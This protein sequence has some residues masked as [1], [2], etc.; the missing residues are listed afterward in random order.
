M[1]AI[2]FM[3][4]KN[5]LY[6]SGGPQN[7]FNLSLNSGGVFEASLT[8]PSPVQANIRGT[9]L[10][11]TINARTGDLVVDLTRL[12]ALLPKQDAVEIKGGIVTASIS[13]RGPLNEPS[14][15]GRATAQGLI[16]G[17]P[18]F[19]ASDAKF[20]NFDFNF[21][22]NEARFGP[23]NASIGKKGEASV[24]GTFRFEKWIPNNFDLHIVSTYN[25]PIPFDLAISRITASGN[26]SGELSLS[27]NEN[28]FHVGGDLTA[29][30]TEIAMSDTTTQDN[31][32]KKTSS[33]ITTTNFNLRTGRKVECIFP[34]ADFPIIRANADANTNIRIESDTSIEHYAIVGDVN[35]RSGEIFYFERSF[36]IRQGSLSFN[37][38]ETRFN[39]GLSARAETRDRFNN[40]NVTIAI[41]INNQSLLSF[42]PTFESTPPL[43]QPEILSLMGESFSGSADANNNNERAFFN[44]IGD[45]A[46][47][48]VVVRRAEKLIRDFFHLDMFSMRT[49]FIQNYIFQNIPIFGNSNSTNSNIDDDSTQ[50]NTNSRIASIFDNSTVM[51]GLFIGTDMFIQ[52]MA[53]FRYDPNTVSLGGLRIE[54]EIGFELKSPLFDISW[55]IV[56]T[57]PEY[58]FIPDNK[59]TLSRR[60]TL[61]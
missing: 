56:P 59:I 40:E 19:V 22:A 51:A 47:Q 46:A 41:V 52:L 15:F 3:R 5:E 32:P 48:F 50:D 9:I 39:P 44:S 30:D 33:I 57:H 25:K 43:S 31:A 8:Y 1:F 23:V 24:D 53:S 16:L 54:P 55:N 11:N 29:E 35:L 12:L 60:W 21:V 61:W 20:E 36:Y 17:V 4:Q 10:N 18:K 37:E 7:I 6:I 38:N 28:V 42:T 27:M 45:I 49:Q 58:L 14:F 34:N 2:N 26:A 13:V